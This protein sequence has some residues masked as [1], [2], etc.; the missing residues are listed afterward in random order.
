MRGQ[1][2]KSPVPKNLD[3]TFLSARKVGDLI[4]IYFLMDR[5]EYDDSLEFKVLNVLS[6]IEPTDK[7]IFCFEENGYDFFLFIG[8]RVDKCKG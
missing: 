6:D 4:G 2:Y 8:K 7:F 1:E 3:K 5:L